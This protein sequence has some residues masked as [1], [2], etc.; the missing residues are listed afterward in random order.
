MK[1]R[2]GVIWVCCLIAG[3]ISSVSAEEAAKSPDFSDY[4]AVIMKASAEYNHEFTVQ[5]SRETISYTIKFLTQKGIE[6]YGTQKIVYNPSTE[7]VATVKGSVSLPN[8]STVEISS[9]DIF[10][11]DVVLKGRRRRREIKVAFPSLE[12]GAVV[13]YTYTRSYEGL[14]W[15]SS[16][17]FQSELFTAE[18]EVTFMPWRGN[19]WGYSI[20]NSNIAPEQKETRPG[21][22]KAVTFRRTNIPPLPR[23]NHS[24]Y[25]ESL[26]ESITFYYVS[27]HRGDYWNEGVTRIYKK[28]LDDLMKSCGDAED[29]VREICPDVTMSNDAKIMA[30]YKYVTEEHPPLGMLTKAELE[31]VD[32][33]YREDL[34]KAD[35]IKDLFDF[36]YLTPWQTN[37]MLASLIHAACPKAEVDIVMYVPWDEGKFDPYLKT[38]QQFTD[39]M[40]RVHC[41]GRTYW[42]DPSKRFMPPDMTDWGVKGVKV[43]VLNEDRAIMQKIPLDR[44]QDN[45]SIT[46]ADVTF[47]MEEGMATI[48]RKTTCDPYES[49]D[50]R[51]ALNFFTEAERKDLLE[52]QAREMMGDEAEL[53][54]F[55]VKNLDKVSEPLIIESESRFPYEFEEIGDQILMDFPG[56]ERPTSNP[57]LA[58]T[59]KN[60]VFFKYPYVR[61]Q[62]ITYTL[63]DGVTITDRPK[64]IQI[65][66]GIIVYNMIY[67]KL[68]DN[69]LMLKNT[70]MLKGNLMN[71]EVAEKLRNTYNDILECN[72]KKL[73]LTEVA[74]E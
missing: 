7:T 69:R 32:S 23:E 40:L 2:F 22:H 60:P 59:R 63:P 27:S 55:D 20:T 73:V 6:D 24:M 42:L 36:K 13:E 33:D 50:L 17:S 44:A 1:Y 41:N 71:A 26:A 62:E 29:V 54:S 49:Y 64:N 35:H 31:A 11:K 70:H 5:M 25:Y 48:R 30:L 68:A 4:D 19:P 47:D 45:T 56:F 39:R 72:R 14:H 67:R 74:A 8:G 10:K 21:G 28:G 12:P 9:D 43:L 65:A 15:V 51:C 37:Y 38:M 57:F 16:W 52:S 18:S 3:W 66:D 46:T 53:I 58:E 34:Y 61:K